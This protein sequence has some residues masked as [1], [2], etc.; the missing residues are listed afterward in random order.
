M[1]LLKRVKVCFHSANST[2]TSSELAPCGI[3]LHTVFTQNHIPKPRYHTYIDLLYGLHAAVKEKEERER[4][5]KAIRVER[6]HVK[7]RST[8]VEALLTRL[9]RTQTASL[10]SRPSGTAVPVMLSDV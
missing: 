6:R 8:R 1:Q 9:C 10:S 4:V 3:F 7:V 5:R 2:D